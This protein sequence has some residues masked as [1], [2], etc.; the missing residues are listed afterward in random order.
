MLQKK[1]WTVHCNFVYTAYIPGNK[2][3]FLNQRL[4]DRNIGGK[5]NVFRKYD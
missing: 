2:S 4:Q 1:S 3:I 5:H